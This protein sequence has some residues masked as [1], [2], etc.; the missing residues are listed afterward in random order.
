[1]TPASHSRPRPLRYVERALVMVGIVTLGYCGWVWAE[2]FLYQSFENRELEK[3]LA[4]GPPPSPARP[5][6]VA[7]R[8]ITPGSTIGRIEIP[9]LR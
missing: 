1:M 4:S 2:S 9:R 8:A 5:G 7:V 6:G 3:I